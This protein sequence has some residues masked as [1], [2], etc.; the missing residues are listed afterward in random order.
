MGRWRFFM[1][2]NAQA[3]IIGI[4]DQDTFN[5]YKSYAYKHKLIRN[6]RNTQQII[7]EAESTTGAHIGETFNESKGPQVIYCDVTDQENQTEL[8]TKQLENLVNQNISFL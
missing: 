3:G 7:E 8:L 5:I 2:S 4:F 6:C 1:D